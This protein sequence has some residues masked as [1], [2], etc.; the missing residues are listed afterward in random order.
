MSKYHALKGN[1]ASTGKGLCW[2]HGNHKSA[3]LGPTIV[4]LRLLQSHFDGLWEDSMEITV[5]FRI[6][7]GRKKRSKF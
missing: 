2:E 6:G 1:P 4:I 5:S 7:E 3:V